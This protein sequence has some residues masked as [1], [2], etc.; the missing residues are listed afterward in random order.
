MPD[1]VKYPHTLS[2]RRKS[3]AKSG[4][5]EI[6]KNVNWQTPTTKRFLKKPPKSIRYGCKRC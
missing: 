2:K 6:D 5:I 4:N 3:R 1:G